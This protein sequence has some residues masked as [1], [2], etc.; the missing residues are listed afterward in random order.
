MQLVQYF[1]DNLLVDLDRVYNCPVKI[2]HDRFNF[3]LFKRPGNTLFP[4]VRFTSHSAR[5]QVT[6]S[7]LQTFS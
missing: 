4:A 6:I 5:N 2:E 7:F 1:S 3:Y